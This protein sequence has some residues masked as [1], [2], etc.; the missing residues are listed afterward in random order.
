MDHGDVILNIAIMLFSV[1][2]SW[3]VIERINNFP[4]IRRFHVI[5]S[6]Y[7]SLFSHKKYAIFF[8]KQE[9]KTDVFIC[10]SSWLIIF[11]TIIFTTALFLYF[12]NFLSRE[13]VSNID[14]LRAIITC[15]LIFIIPQY[16]SRLISSVVLWKA[17]QEVYNLINNGAKSLCVFSDN[18]RKAN[19][20][21]TDSYNAHPEKFHTKMK[22]RTKDSFVIL[23]LLYTTS[24]ALI[25]Y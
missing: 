6:F 22:H 13:C 23:L 10:L 24:F 20:M 17:E 14:K 16:V 21:C 4:N 1:S 25:H 19:G 15:L 5:H 2:F 7:L 3:V 9:N 18:W 8:Q 12:S 11:S